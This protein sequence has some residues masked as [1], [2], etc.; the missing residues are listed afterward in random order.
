MAKYLVLLVLAQHHLA[1]LKSCLRSLH[2][3]HFR[4]GSSL[5]SSSSTQRGV[6]RRHSPGWQHLL[7]Q[8]T[9]KCLWSGT[10]T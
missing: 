8:G 3:R 7:S 1:Y 10:P 5:Y 4:L 2:D 6:M 9:N